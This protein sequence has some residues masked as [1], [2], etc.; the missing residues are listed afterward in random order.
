MNWSAQLERVYRVQD[1]HGILTRPEHTIR[2]SSED[3]GWGSLYASLQHEA[4]YEACFGAVEDHL[5][6]LHLGGPVAVER[7]LGGKRERRI[8]PAWPVHPSG[9]HRFRGAAGRRAGHAAHLS[10]P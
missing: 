1:T 8:V 6:I 2:A 10:A 9:R 7:D 3:L 5:L 4:P